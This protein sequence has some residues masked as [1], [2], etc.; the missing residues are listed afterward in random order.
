MAL[1]P[2]ACRMIQIVGQDGDEN[3]HKIHDYDLAGP[4]LYLEINKN[5]SNK[6]HIQT[7]RRQIDCWF[8]LMDHCIIII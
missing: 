5:K 4:K 7:I 8:D 3:P 1:L 6:I 2:P